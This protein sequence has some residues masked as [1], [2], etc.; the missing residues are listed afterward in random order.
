MEDITYAAL[1]LNLVSYPKN[2]AGE[3]KRLLVNIYIFFC[4]KT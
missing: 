4:K 2:D 1:R 3:F